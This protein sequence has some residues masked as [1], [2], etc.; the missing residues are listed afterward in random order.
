MKKFS[1]NNQINSSDSKQQCCVGVDVS[2][3]SLDLCLHPMNLHKQF[4]NSPEGIDKCITF[5]KSFQVDTILCEATGGY[6]W[7]FIIAFNHAGFPVARANPKQIRDYARSCGQLAKTDT[8]DAKIIAQFAA[9]RHPEPLEL[10]S[11]TQLELQAL[12]TFRGQLVEHR[13]RLNNQ[14]KQSTSRCVGKQV[15]ELLLSLKEKIALLDKEIAKLMDSDEELKKLDEILQSVPG[16]GPVMSHTLIA[17]CSRLGECTGSEIASYSGVAPLNCDSGQK[18]GSRHIWGGNAN[19]RKAAYMA[20]M[21]GAVQGR[22][23]VLAA[24]YDRLRKAG[25]AFKVAATACMRKLLVILNKLVQLGEKWVD[26]LQIS[27]VTH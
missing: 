15:E 22:N 5:L 4:E 19:I 11:E 6:E 20:V 16:V 9:E 17:E 13:D 3:D 14:G 12:L 21:V 24:F 26:K 18:R 23:P 27:S 25:K 1:R 8:I 10:P 7:R 2:K